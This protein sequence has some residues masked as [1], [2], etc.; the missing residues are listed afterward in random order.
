ML[1]PKLISS[2]TSNPSIPALVHLLRFIFWNNSSFNLLIIIRKWRSF[3][4]YLQCYMYLI[5]DVKMFSL[6]VLLCHFQLQQLNKEKKYSLLF[7]NVPFG[8]AWQVTL[9]LTAWIPSSPKFTNRSANYYNTIIIL[10]IIIWQK[11]L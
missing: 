9:L 1:K 11:Q 2:W 4:S 5:L 3:C 8:Q 7:S 6:Q 10:I